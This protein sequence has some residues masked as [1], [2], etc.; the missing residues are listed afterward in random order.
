MEKQILTAHNLSIGI[1]HELIAGIN[2]G[3]ADK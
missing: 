1:H 2:F 3:R